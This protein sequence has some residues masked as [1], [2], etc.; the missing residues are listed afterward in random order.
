MRINNR[1]LA[2]R[3]PAAAAS[4]GMPYGIKVGERRSVPI[5]LRLS[6]LD[7]NRRQSLRTQMQTQTLQKSPYAEGWFHQPAHRF[8]LSAIAILSS[9]L[10][11]LSSNCAAYSWIQTNASGTVSRFTVST[12][13][14]NSAECIHGWIQATHSDTGLDQSLS[15][16]Y[17]YK[18][19][20][21]LQSSVAVAPCWHSPAWICRR[22]DVSC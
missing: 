21:L 3:F 9:L 16:Q 1:K 11:M 10:S 7:V 12:L 14:S 19:D 4:K 15:P 18:K 22:H 17:L 2:R 6:V 8:R 5:Q 13:S 20:R